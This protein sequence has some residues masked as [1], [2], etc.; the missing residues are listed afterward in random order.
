MKG[1]TVTMNQSVEHSTVTGFCPEQAENTEV[2]MISSLIS[3]K[4]F[5][6]AAYQVTTLRKQEAIPWGV[7]EH[8]KT[9]KA[10]HHI[11]YGK[12]KHDHLKKKKKKRPGTSLV[13]Q[14]LRLLASTA[15]D[16]G[17]IPG[18]GTKIPYAMQ[19]SQKKKKKRPFL[20][21]WKKN[22]KRV[23]LK[24]SHWK[25]KKLNMWGEGRVLLTQ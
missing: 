14:W 16:T 7:L 21:H 20:K 15:G 2:R 19:C 6:L 5:I 17:S 22:V 12:F 23:E 25:E 3:S 24:R 4:T 18:P 8:T 9:Q 10:N 11:S 1:C 13:V